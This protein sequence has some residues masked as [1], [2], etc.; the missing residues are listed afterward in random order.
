MAAKAPFWTRPHLFVQV[1]AGTGSPYAVRV[2]SKKLVGLV[3]F[4]GIAYCVFLTGSLLFFRELEVSRKL[5]ERV[6][7][8]ETAQKLSQ[9]IQ[10][11]SRTVA[12]SGMAGVEPAA[13]KPALP[14][15]PSPVAAAAPPKVATTAPAEAAKMAAPVGTVA[16]R[17][18]DLTNSC[19]EDGCQAKI[20]MVPVASGVAQGQLL[21][22]LETEIPRIGSANPG[23]S[24][25]R[26]FFSYPG[27][28]T[29]DDMTQQDLEQL[30]RK[31]FRF[32]RALQTAVKFNIG[33]LL[34]PLAVN[35]YLF[36]SAGNRTHHERKTIEREE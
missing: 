5:Q 32:S 19:A 22:I 30:P 12:A 1:H 6:L 14:A 2:N 18:A 26:R 21:V 10:L 15:A 16:A 23:S 4:L 17:I 31:A 34:R 7:E 3:L 24:V 25:R 28:Q 36:D 20:S 35:V 11:A 27:N 8:F 9:Q 13:P 33:K 29:K